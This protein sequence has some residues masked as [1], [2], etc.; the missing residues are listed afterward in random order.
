MPS[1]TTV[2][3]SGIAAQA[4][5]TDTMHGMPYSRATIEA[6]DRIPPASATTPAARAKSGVQATSEN[7][8]TMMSPARTRPKSA[9]P[10]TTLA[11]P[12][13]EPREV[14]IPASV[15]RTCSA[16]GRATKASP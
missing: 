3:P 14:G 2:A 10:R 15:A 11:G 6:C 5:W 13:T 9:A 12:R 1:T 16:A 4:P 7:G 8:I